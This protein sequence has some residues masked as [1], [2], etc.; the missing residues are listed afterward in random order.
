MSEDSLLAG[1]IL[2]FLDN[3]VLFW[4][5]SILDLEYFFSGVTVSILAHELSLNSLF[6]F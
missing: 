2:V 6:H 3:S 5:L 4:S 1:F